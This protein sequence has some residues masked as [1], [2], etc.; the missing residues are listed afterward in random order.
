MLENSKFNTMTIVTILRFM[1][2]ARN[3]AKL[4]SEGKTVTWQSQWGLP[5]EERSSRD[6][7][8]PTCRQWSELI[9]VILLKSTLLDDLD[10]ILK[11]NTPDE[12]S[13]LTQSPSSSSQMF[14]WLASSPRVS[15][16]HYHTDNTGISVT[17]D[18]ESGGWQS[19][20]ECPSIIAVI[21]QWSTSWP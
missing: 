15:F 11:I 7:E 17:S 18:S 8:S 5:W 6:D 19:P 21:N 1:Y 3:H 13:H 10:D 16:G 9:W 14:S 4:K 20:P 12:K 2:I